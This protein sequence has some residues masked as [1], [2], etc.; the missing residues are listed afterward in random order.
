MKEESDKEG[1]KDIKEE[2]KEEK[3]G[4]EKEV[5]ERVGQGVKEME[6]ESGKATAGELPPASFGTITE[7]EAER[8]YGASFA[9]RFVRE[10]LLT[11]DCRRDPRGRSQCVL[12]LAV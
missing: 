11:F 12:P 3:V 6:G 10:F 2:T 8:K 5:K 1:E 4:E 9:L 7:K